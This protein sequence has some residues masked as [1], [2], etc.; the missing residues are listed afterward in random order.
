M[1]VAWASGGAFALAL[2]GCAGGGEARGTA[3]VAP[4]TDPI[5]DDGSFTRDERRALDE[6]AATDP[7]F[8]LRLGGRAGG[9]RG[10]EGKAAASDEALRRAAVAALLA[11]DADA[12]V[13]DGA[14]DFFSFAARS[15]G[16]D[17]AARIVGAARATADERAR[18]AEERDLPRS[19]SE[20]VRGM[21]DTWGPAE[22]ME[23]MKER[24]GWAARRLDQV[25][26]SLSGGGRALPRVELIELDDALD[27]LERLASPSEYAATAG[28]LAR[29]RV[30]LGNV[31]PAAGRDASWPRVE[32]QLRAHLG[33]AA[34]A[35]ELRARLE[36]AR[37]MLRAAIVAEG[38]RA[39]HADDHAVLSA[40][41]SLAF[42][43]GRCA[44]SASESP[45]RALVPP[46]ERAAICGAL[47]SLDGADAGDAR[48]AALAAMDLEVTTALWALAVHS[49]GVDPDRAQERT[50]PLFPPPPE[51]E[52]RVLRLAVARPVVA[53]GAGLAVEILLR[54]AGSDVTDLRAPAR[55][56]LAFGDAPLDV[57]E[58]D[59]FAD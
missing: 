1:A 4:A 50:R 22:T 21:I 57:I 41:E 9:E 23:A 14:L 20:L 18:L 5:A 54:H 56:W 31:T 28:A 36:A 38:K 49:A 11:E 59:V 19:A 25:R 10:A 47:R 7:R 43:P 39:G 17:T 58:R 32:A 15:R 27:P 46:P 45:V 16:L 51:R 33:V 12:M 37:S 24:D 34:R 48:L 40:A 35:P 3:K 42:A 13:H 44:A 29:L 26:A 8:A 30:A 53:L 52:V 55:R 6:V 2:A